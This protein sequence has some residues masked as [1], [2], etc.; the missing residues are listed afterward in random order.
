MARLQ[1][2]LG[3]Q[4]GTG[5]EAHVLGTGFWPGCWVTHSRTHGD[6]ACGLT[7]QRALPVQGPPASP[8]RLSYTHSSA[9][10]RRAVVGP[11]AVHPAL[12]LWALVRPPAAASIRE[13]PA[14]VGSPVL[15]PAQERTMFTCMR[16]QRDGTGYGVGFLYPKC[17][18]PLAHRAASDFVQP[19][20]PSILCVCVPCTCAW[21]RV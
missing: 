2:L 10:P 16:G 7:V 13:H 19:T 21:E 14:H 3:A 20:P 15:S 8:Q 6:S 11:Q 4:P 1:R 9:P 17:T 12:P 5:G 18:G